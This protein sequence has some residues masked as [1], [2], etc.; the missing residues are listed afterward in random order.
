MK[1]ITENAALH[2]SEDPLPVVH[3]YESESL[4]KSRLVQQPA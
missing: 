2:P 1:N 4:S 3:G